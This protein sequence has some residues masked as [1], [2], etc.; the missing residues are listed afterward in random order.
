VDDPRCCQDDRGPDED[1][2][3]VLDRRVDQ[4]AISAAHHTDVRLGIERDLAPGTERV[5]GLRQCPRV[6]GEE[7]ERG[8][9]Q[10]ERERDRDRED[11]DR[12]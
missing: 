12:Q 11:A 2:R 8:P 10:P 7:Q 4:P 3:R 9:E 1:Q 5:H 6:H